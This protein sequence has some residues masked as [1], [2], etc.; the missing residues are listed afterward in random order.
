MNTFSLIRLLTLS[1]AV[2]PTLVRAVPTVG[3]D[4]ARPTL[5]LRAEF[6][7]A[8]PAAADATPPAAPGDVARGHWWRIFADPK[9]D[10]LEERA[11]AGN[12]DLQAAAARVEQA[13]AAAGIARAG[14]W[15]E[16]AVSAE[17]LR[18]RTSATTDNP[19]PRRTET[20]YRLPLV[21]SWELDLFGRVRRLNES[22]RA[23]ATAAEADGQAVGLALTTEVAATYF[24]L[25][26]ARAETA[27]LAD[28][29]QWRRRALEVVSARVHAGTA[30]DVDAAR[31]ETELAVAEAEAAASARRREALRNALAV[32]TGE[33]PVR[34]APDAAA[35]PG[36]VPLV[37]PGLPA[38]V[39]AR[40]PD[41]AAAER[42]LAAASAQIGV[43]RAAYLPAI[44]LT[45]GAGYASG[46]L[47]RLF[48]A[49]SR[50]WSFGPRIYLPLFQGGRIRAGVARSR[51]AFDE[52]AALYRQQVLVALR[53][54]Q[55]GLTASR[56]LA[57]EAAA[58]ER[59]VGAAKRTV[60][61]AQRRY[62][63]G[64]VGYLE[65]IDA[66]RTALGSE[67]AAVL[68]RAQRL[69]AAVALIKALGGGWAANPRLA[70]NQS[71]SP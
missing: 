67:R 62:D 68:L 70:A 63:A 10:A 56:L 54:V 50:L 51:A 21:A 22:A 35:L 15:P 8:P 46:D 58:L 38:E 27:L 18:D 31:A 12:Q 26:G 36:S 1:L 29:V 39:I 64:Y 5:D 41:V 2:L 7:D 24:S 52:A 37:P 55:D 16:L 3:P 44:S 45:G 4:Y 53:E 30:A 66:Q 40:R 6:R 59:A 61:L 65:V 23:A 11:L 47:D 17:V 42:R 28:T 60:A 33:D 71:I 25:A 57:D 19:L 34:E 49:G 48:D 13:R 9:L 43:A 32:L 14:Y 69:N 20:T